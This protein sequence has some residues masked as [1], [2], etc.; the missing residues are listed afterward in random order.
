L[1]LTWVNPHHFYLKISIAIQN[2]MHQCF[3]VKSC[4]M[5]TGAADHSRI[6]AAAKAWYDPDEA[7]PVI[8]IATVIETWNSAPCPLGTHMLIH[9]DGRFTGSV[10]GGCVEGDVLETASIVIASGQH[11]IRR[12]GLS[13][14]AA[15][16]AGLPCGGDIQVLIQPVSE[17]GFPVSLFDQITLAHAAGE[18]VTISTDLETGQSRIAQD[19][20][21]FTNIYPPPRR[22]LIVG[23]VEIAITLAQI[24]TAAGINVTL[25]DPRSRFLTAERFPGIDLDD[26]WPD[27]AVTALAPDSRTAIVTLSH[28]PKIDDPALVAA[29]ASPAG[30]IAALGSKTSQAARRER[31]L[32]L[33]VEATQLDR[34][35]GPAGVA[36]NAI[37]AP[38]I[39]LSIASGMIRC[40]NEGLR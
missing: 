37:S 9:R 24:A 2:W 5:Q 3:G 23:A 13:D 21:A 32:S 10:S 25:I 34:V 36:I 19:A 17:A 4:F 22:L 18:T 28:D 39:A 7:A 38:E 14:G 11:Q 1:R 16:E 27:E 29:L 6:L 8:A 12:Y 26:R 30:Y 15:W 31:L 20:T 35:E 33:G 40:F